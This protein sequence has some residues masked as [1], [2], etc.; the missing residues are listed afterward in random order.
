MRCHHCALPFTRPIAP[1]I[2]VPTGCA[3]TGCFGTVVLFGAFLIGAVRIYVGRGLPPSPTTASTRPQ[4]SE[5]RKPKDAEQQHKDDA[6]ERARRAEQ[7]KEEKRRKD[8]QEARR[9]AEEKKAEERAAAY[10]QYAKKLIDRGETEKAQERLQEIVRD[11]PHTEAAKEAR[12]LL[13]T[14]PPPAQR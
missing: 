12:Q 13:Q 6:A 1:G 11:L 7:E 5:D 4:Q 10:L 2:H 3:L 14:L 9:K 8:Q